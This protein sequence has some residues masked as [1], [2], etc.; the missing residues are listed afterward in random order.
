[1]LIHIFP[2]QNAH[3]QFTLHGNFC[4]QQSQ[5]AIPCTVVQEH[6][7]MFT[8]LNCTHSLSRTLIPH[9]YFLLERSQTFRHKVYPQPATCS[10]P[11]GRYKTWTLDCGLDYGLDD[12]DWTMDSIWTWLDQ[13]EGSATARLGVRDFEIHWISSGFRI[14]EWISGFLDFKVDFW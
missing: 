3:K 2:A 6:S 13:C 7:Q 5:M 8:K 14:S 1:M 4:P 9:A 11:R 10:R 12:M